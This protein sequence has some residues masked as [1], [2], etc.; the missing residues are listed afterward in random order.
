MK[1]RAFLRTT[2]GAALGCQ[3][4]P[5]RV[6]GAP[7]TPGPNSRIR[8]AA[9]GAGGQA[10]A[11]LNEMAAEHI[12]AL[13]DVDDARAA[14]MF[15]RFPEARRYR[16]FRVMLGEMA[17]GIDAVL[18]GTPDHTHAV[19]CRAAMAL[20]KPVYCEK[21]LAH[22]VAEVRALRR[23]AA[24]R[25]LIT[26]VGNQGHSTDSIRVF[27]EWVRD[28]AIGEVT[29]VHAGIESSSGS[30]FQIN[31]LAQ[32]RQERPAVPETLDWPLWQGPVPERP[33][34]PVY[35][36]GT[37]RGWSAY[38]TGAI[39]DWICHVLDPAYW[40]LDLDLPTSI[41][42]ETDGYDPV[43]HR[44]VFPHGSRITFR[45]PARAGRGPV[46][47]IWHEGTF[48]IPRPPQLEDDR[49]VVGTGAVVYGTTG[50]IMH[51]SHGAS[52]CR[53]IPEAAMQAYQRPEPSIPRVPA[54]H[55]RDWLNAIREGRPAG[56]PFAYAGRLTEVGL[57]GIIAMRLSDQELLYDPATGRFTNSEVA[58]TL[59]QSPYRT[60]WTRA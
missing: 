44:D 17:D 52:G 54:G 28:G 18:V 10:A 37:W 46:K 20:N 31:R 55:H 40:A 58:N 49:S 29:E 7:G 6:L 45:F 23:E 48:R 53:L 16:D 22:D 24:E 59:L 3:I 8:L 51:G 15:A 14:E 60:G 39:G 42:A 25:R 41:H 36:P 34:H 27:A 13:C 35:V 50:A 26:Q 21:P 38:G 33:Y 4:L 9:I 30:Y 56:S 12:V 2:A 1:R 57:L 11:D 47:V 43:E 5:R 32:V 19:A